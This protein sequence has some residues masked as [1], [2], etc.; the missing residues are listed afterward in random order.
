MKTISRLLGIFLISAILSNPV[1][2][3][4]KEVR[5]GTQAMFSAQSLAIAKG[6]FAEEF[7][8]LGLK[9]QIINAD[10]GRDI[11]NGLASKSIDFGFLGTTPFVVANQRGLDSQSFFVDFFYRNNEAIVVKKGTDIKSVADLKGKK[12][13][14]PLGTSSHYLLNEALKIHNLSLNDVEI[15]DLIPQD[16]FA[17]WSRNDIEVAVLWDN[18]LS[19]LQNSEV[20]FSDEDLSKNGILNV[21]LHIAR[22]EFLDKNPEYVQAYI[23]ALERAIAD[24]KQ[25][26][27]AANEVL[28]KYFS[29]PPEEAKKYLEKPMWKNLAQQKEIYSADFHKQLYQVAL[30][31]K[32]NDYLPKI[33]AEEEFK[34]LIRSEFINE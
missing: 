11:N 30:F 18:V 5:I 33:N 23:R 16:I 34:K 14:V 1:F 19:S 13:A 10:T 21:C 29:L 26:F 22:K 12:I 27:N 7:Q 25:D 6:Y 24:Y 17:A 9:V 2:A 20:L 31:L 4:D 28:A 32:E 8:K 15:V 3:K